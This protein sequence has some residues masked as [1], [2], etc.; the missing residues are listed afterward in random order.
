MNDKRI[1]LRIPEPLHNWLTKT[2]DYNGTTVTAEIH[3]IILAAKDGNLKDGLTANEIN[4]LIE[5]KL[6]HHGL[7]PTDPK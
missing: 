5:K 7:I 1:T 4:D 6:K 2:A 3:K